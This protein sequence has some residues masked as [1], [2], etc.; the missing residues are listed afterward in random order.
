VNVHVMPIGDIVEHVDS[1]ECVCGPKMK[2]VS[3][4]DGSIG[5][6]IL[7]SS[8]DGREMFE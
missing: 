8:L 2:P 7:H 1:D 4:D 6:V 5:W 3:R